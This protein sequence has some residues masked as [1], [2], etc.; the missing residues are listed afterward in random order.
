MKNWMFKLLLL[1]M[2]AVSLEAANIEKIYIPEESVS[3]YDKQILVSFGLESV[4]ILK[5]FSDSQGLF[6]LREDLPLGFW[7]CRNGHANYP[8]NLVCSKCGST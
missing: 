2:A 5:V 6:I 7:V 3:I 4:P 8:W 1:G